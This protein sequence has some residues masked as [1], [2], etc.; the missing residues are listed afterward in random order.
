M[1]QHEDFC[2]AGRVE[3]RGRLVE[4][5]KPRPHR[6]HR[7]DADPLLLAARQV[8]DGVVAEAVEADH[9]QRLGL[10]LQDLGRGSAEVFQTEADL[11]AHPRADDL[12]V[13]V[14]E[15]HADVGREGRHLGRRDRTAADRGL[16]GQ[17]AL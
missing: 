16:P 8:E 7:R 4:H 13:G 15:H 12:R 2:H 1:Q 9:M 5:E 10:S 6:Q 14:L 3:V 17:R 11:V